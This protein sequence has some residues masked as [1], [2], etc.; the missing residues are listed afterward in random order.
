MIYFISR[1]LS[2]FFSPILVPTYGMILALYTSYVSYVSFTTKLGVIGITFIITALLPFSVIS[3][4]YKLGKISDIG[5]NQRKDRLIPILSATICY[6][7]FAIYLYNINAPGWMFSFAIGATI[8][9]FVAGIVNLWWKLS[10]H[11]TGIG[12]LLALTFIISAGKIYSPGINPMLYFS[13]MTLLV[14]LIGTSR[15]VLNRHTLW[16]VIAG[17]AN[18]IISMLIALLIS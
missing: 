16:Q 10:G 18:G 4:L 15:L 1:I 7:I 14:G 5:V 11:C 8:A 9:S 3:I 12:G 13:I 6:I 2:T 17:T